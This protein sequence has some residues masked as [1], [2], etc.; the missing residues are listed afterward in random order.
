MIPPNPTG[1]PSTLISRYEDVSKCGPPKSSIEMII[2][3]HPNIWA[4]YEINPYPNLRPFWG[5]L[6]LLFTTIWGDLGGLVVINWPEIYIY[7]SSGGWC[8]RK[9]SFGVQITILSFGGP[10]CLGNNF[11]VK[12]GCGPPP[13]MPV[14]TRINYS[15]FSR[16]S[17]PKPSFPTVTVNGPHPR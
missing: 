8:F 6:P 16:E 15:I 14:T 11:W 9:K 2:H 1:H 12:F 5:T 17:Q 3:S 4:T 7:I 13:R 10:G